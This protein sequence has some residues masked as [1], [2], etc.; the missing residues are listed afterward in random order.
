MK[1]EVQLVVVFM[2]NFAMMVVIKGMDDKFI[3][4]QPDL[5]CL[6][7][8]FVHTVKAIMYPACSKSLKSCPSIYII[9]ILVFR[10]I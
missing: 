1:L 6:F 4:K 10:T 8:L 5:R 9:F 3:S 2:V 7:H